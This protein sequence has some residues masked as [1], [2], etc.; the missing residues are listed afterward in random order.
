MLT[1][2]KARLARPMPFFWKK[3]QKRSAATSAAFGALTVTVSA[4]AN[5]LPAILPTAL[6]Y[7]TAFFGAIAATC[8][9][10]VDDPT[11]L[12][13]AEPLPVAEQTNTAQL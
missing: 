2:I 12:P 3:L 7:L 6:G 13:T 4:I 10:A 5:H 8:T 1:E 9:L 11:T